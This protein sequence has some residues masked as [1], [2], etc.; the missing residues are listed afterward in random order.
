MKTGSTTH[1]ANSTYNLGYVT[2]LQ[3]GVWYRQHGLEEA[4]SEALR[5]ADIFDELGDVEDSEHCRKLLR[6][7]ENSMAVSDQTDTD[8]KFLKILLFPARI[9]SPL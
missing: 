9:D 7:V 8:C 1:T 3:A 4:K 6:E 5:A 2:R